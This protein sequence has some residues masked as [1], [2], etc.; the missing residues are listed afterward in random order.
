[1][2]SKVDADMITPDTRDL[3]VPSEPRKTVQVRFPR[4][5][6]YEGPVGTSLETF[7]RAARFD[8]SA[9]IVAAL[10]NGVLAELT[11]PVV[12]DVDVEPISMANSDGMRIYQ[13]SLTL[14]LVVAAKQLFPAAQL[15]VDYAVP[16]SGF[17]CEVIGRP[18]LSASELA[19]LERRMRA[20][21]RDNAPIVKQEV[22]VPDA[23]RI[24]REYGYD[25]KARLLEARTKDYITMY[26]LLG[27]CDSFYGHMV[28]STGYLEYFS[29]SHQEGGFALHFPTRFQARDMP[30]VRH[31]PQLISVFFEYGGWL[32]LL[33]V[34]DVAA[35]NASIDSGRIREVVL[36]SEALHEDRAAWIAHEIAER[37]PD[38]S[39]VL[40]AG[41]SS[42]GK[43]TFARRLAIQLLA[44]K[45]KPVYVG[46]D[47]YFVDRDQTPL[48][49]KGKPDFEAL[50]AIDLE[51]FNRH[52]LELMAA[53]PVQIPRFNFVT[54]KRE[55]GPTITMSEQHVILV[56]GIHGLNPGLV[57]DI[58][59]KNIYRVYL[60]PL[61]QLNLDHH[62]R[63]PTSDTRLLRRM[64]RD[65]VKRGR[66]ATSTI[67]Q[68]ESVRQ[69]EV[70]WIFPYQEN[71]D[72]IF[73]SAL[74]YE[75]AVLKPFAEP[76]LRQVEPGTLEF[77]EAR[78]LLAFL[79]WIKA[80][81]PDLVPDNSLLREFIG[82]SILDDYMPTLG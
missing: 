43:T 77:V 10:V 63:I 21:I 81:P 3:I 78:R 46:L 29:L 9:P 65:A 54:G 28:P 56:E 75:L 12:T 19:Q 1:M 32:Q 69:G 14:L 5:K 7:V 58:P 34:H 53:K 20:I 47:D 31:Y 48:D 11:T 2:D 39:L 6:I 16:L 36:V 41:P 27:H 61:A 24:F 68:W 82:G 57:P 40:I 26:S 23:I 15:F 72:A 25:D 76:L 51:L 42:S 4:R 80:C 52:L 74:V 71:A 13:R 62:N 64:T 66:S 59:A 35:L 49:E 60:S 73:N 30:Q 44:H 8:G 50:G 79:S 37:Q 67:Q 17:F 38:V 55:A 22:A 18:Q 33:G 70:K 45:I